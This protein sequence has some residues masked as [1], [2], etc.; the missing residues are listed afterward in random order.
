MAGTSSSLLSFVQ[1]CQ[2]RQQGP[3]T[4]PAITPHFIHTAFR[5]CCCDGRDMHLCR[6]RRTNGY[7]HL[8][9]TFKDSLK[10]RRY[11][12]RVPLHPKAF[13]HFA[14]RTLPLSTRVNVV[15]QGESAANGQRCGIS[16]QSR[17]LHHKNHVFPV[18][19]IPLLS[20]DRGTDS[21]FL[22]P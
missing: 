18:G 11:V 19:L 12:K 17:K 7:T 8:L 14:N 13:G 21:Q 3:R 20:I 16:R 6:Q 15:S 1:P 9:T 4:R 22:Q 10:P 2:S 5:G